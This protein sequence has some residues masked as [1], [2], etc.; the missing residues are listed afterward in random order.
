MAKFK[1]TQ[2]ERLT[3]RIYIGIVKDNKDAKRAGR[4]RVWIPEQ[5]G[6]EFDE[7]NWILCDY[8]TP[9]GGAT[10]RTKNSRTIVDTQQDTQTAYG[11]WA[12][13]PD[14]NS[15]VLV[16]FAGGLVDRAFW[17]GC[18][19]KEFMLHEVPGI[20]ASSRNKN[21]APGAT[22]AGEPIPVSEY[23]KWDDTIDAKD[24]LDPIRPWHETRTKGIGEQ[25]LIKDKIRGITSSSAM[26]ESPSQVFGMSTPGPIDPRKSE[27]I[28]IARLGGH[29]FV[30]DDGDADGN[31]EYIGLRTRSGAMIR[32]DETN[33]LIYAI[34]KKGT[35]WIQMDADGNVDIFGAESISMR[36]Q[37][38]FNL[39][40]D[41]NVN[42]EAGQNINM[43]AAQDSDGSAIVGEGSGTGGN[44][45]LQAA[46][47]MNVL[48]D[49]NL[50]TTV[51]NGNMDIDIQSGNLT[52]HIAGS[53]DLRVD[54]DYQETVGGS[55]ATKSNN[56]NIDNNGN[57]EINGTF[58][59]ANKI[60]TDD[61]VVAQGTMF[62]TDFRAPNAG[63]VG[64][65][66][67]GSNPA[68][69]G[70][71][72]GTTTS[73]TGPEASTATA[74]GP[75]PTFTKTNILL[76]FNGKA[77]IKLNTDQQGGKNNAAISTETE[78]I[79]NY[80][81]RLTEEVDTIVPRFMTYEPCPDHINKGGQEG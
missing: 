32:I 60:S 33:G 9:F 59:A 36:T 53:Q 27:A 18:L 14:I 13:P 21:N 8:C 20:A 26:R 56:V 58:H 73:A 66:H 62:A 50:S 12:V 76:G 1:R 57:M 72:T 5:E 41:G 28:G 45:N 42:I 3:D 51:S 10:N 43:K 30:M 79:T 17:I 11:F 23:N 78:Q 19:Y 52:E 6:N 7:S 29:T 61:D 69:G 44:I 38:D 15:E 64:H 48:V 35:S 34:N 40:A 70:G 31:D 71:G 77:V 2:Q 39:R 24:E 25:G 4:L 55:T 46:N 54:G 80:W 74:V 22:N 47:D 81:D 68:T 63:L 37:K 65:T 67:G 49:D 16:C 75:I